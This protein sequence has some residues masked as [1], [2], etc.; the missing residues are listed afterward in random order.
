MLLALLSSTSRRGRI[1]EN[2]LLRNELDQNFDKYAPICFLYE[3]SL[4]RAKNISAELRQNYLGAGSLHPQ[5]SLK[6]LSELFADSLTGFGVHRFVHLAA[7]FTK[8]YYYRFS[9]EG[10]NSHIYY[11]NVTPYGVV[12]HDDLLYL[13]VE[14][15]VSRMYTSNDEEY[16]IIEIITRMFASFAYKGDPNKSTDHF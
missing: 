11:P 12:H 4:P 2:N 6:G 5:R 3:S 16:Q 1:L 9:Y 13:F 8:V 15:S 7:R 14:P 10:R